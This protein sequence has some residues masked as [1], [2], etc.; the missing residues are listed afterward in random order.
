MAA[1]RTESQGPDAWPL[2]GNLPA[3]PHDKLGFLARCAEHYGDTGPLQIGE[4][5]Y[6]LNDAARP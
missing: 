4:P 3:F 6:L 2:L 1:A 5:T